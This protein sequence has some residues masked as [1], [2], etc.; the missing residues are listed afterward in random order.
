MAAREA[1]HAGSWY[2]R[3]GAR[4]AEELDGWLGEAARTCPPARALIA[5]HAGYAYSGAVAAWAYAHVDPTAVRRVFLL[6]PSHHV[7]TP[8]CALTG[9]A[10]YRTPLGSLKVDAEASDALR[11]TGE[12]EEMTKKADEEEHSLEMHLPY[13]VHVMRG[14]EFGLVPVLVGALSEESEAKYGKLFSQYLTDP[15]NLF[16]FSSDFCHWG[17]RFRFT[18]FSEKGK[19]I[20][21][22][23]EQ[24]DRQGMA[25]VE[26]QDAAGF[27]AYLRE[28][29]NTICGRHPIAILLHAL[30]ACGSVEHKVK[31]VRY[32][33]S[34]L[35]RS[36]NDSSVSYASAVVHV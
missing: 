29:G 27:A 17:R 24:L 35:C 1:T 21:Q 14:R 11:R 5:P 2:S 33:M 20:H 30:Q 31:F 15:E 18:P 28:F 23:I 3:D 16:V 34:S 26:A 19:Q 6:G 10:E 12:F 4:L 32:A 22:S 36:I 7:Y 25:L 9:C 8:R 13:I